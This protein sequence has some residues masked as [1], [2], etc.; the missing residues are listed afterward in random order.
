MNPFLVYV[1]SLAAGILF[2]TLSARMLMQQTTLAVIKP[3]LYFVVSSL[4]RLGAISL[5]GWFLLHWGTLPLIL[6]GGSLLVAKWL[7]IAAYN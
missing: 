1:A 5:V 2:G 6:F 3:G 7:V 4:V